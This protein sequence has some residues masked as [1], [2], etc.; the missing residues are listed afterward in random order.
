MQPLQT[1]PSCFSGRTT[2][3]RSR[4]IR[5]GARRRRH[6]CHDCGHRWTAFTDH[7]GRPID[8][9]P[10]SKPASHIKPG[11]R[12]LT[13][14]DVR[15]ILTRPDL[16]LGLLADQLQVSRETIRQVRIG[17]TYDDVLPGLPRK[18][19]RI[20]PVQQVDGPSCHRCQHWRSGCDLGFPDPEL[21]GPA[22]A[23]D[24]SL[25]EPRSQSI[26]RACPSSLQ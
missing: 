24:C 16:S 15:L 23:A 20:A 21:E 1:C 26:S 2:T 17:I 13:T 8:Q 14:D 4:P 6:C 3:L 22:F 11:L 12:R 5:D 25:Y 19:P 7:R 9:P 18:R 10:P